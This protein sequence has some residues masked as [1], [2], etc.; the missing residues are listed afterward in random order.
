M[1][2]LDTHQH[3]IDRGRFGYGWAADIPALA[4]GNF[5]TDDYRALAGERVEATLFM[6]VAVDDGDF[7]AE[8]RHFA[9]LARAG[10]GG[11]AGVIA[12]CRPETDA[13]FDAWLDTCAALGVRGFRRVLHVMPDDLSQSDTFRANL[14][15]IGARGFTFDLC[16][17]AR[18]LPL[19]HDLARACPDVPFILDHCGVPDIAGGAFD[20]WRTGIEAL[21]V[22]PNVTCK[23]SG[24]TAYCTPGT[25]SVE[26]LRPWVDLVIDRFGPGRMV[27]GSDWPVVDLGSGLPDWLAISDAL[28]APLSADERAAIARGT[29]RAL[30]LGGSPA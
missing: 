3:L 25:A 6:E 5:G 16:M 24:L 30:Y 28:L 4:A 1:T 2:Y 10:A 21:A 17:L 12:S 20:A 22:L 14:R 8:A 15:K 7:E 11:I 23:L 29:A 9:G 27:W 13:G 26:T 18:Q 19:A